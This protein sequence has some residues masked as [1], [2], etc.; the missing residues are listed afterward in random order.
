MGTIGQPE[1]VA[2]TMAFLSSH[3]TAGHITGL[4]ISV[5]GGMEGRVV[6]PEEMLNGT[7]PIALHTHPEMTSTK[8]NPK[9]N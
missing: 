3:R 5:D 2:R 9:Y 7:T 6:W 8:G 4:C 1:D